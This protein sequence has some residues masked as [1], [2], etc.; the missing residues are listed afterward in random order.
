M[1]AVVGVRRVGHRMYMIL[2]IL[3][4]IWTALTI[5]G[6]DTGLNLL[7][8]N[9]YEES[10]S[11]NFYAQ[12]C[13]DYRMTLK[14]EEAEEK[15]SFSPCDRGC[16]CSINMVLVDGEVFI[17]T[18]LKGNQSVE[19]KQISIR[20]SI[21][22]KTPSI[23]SVEE[24]RGNFEIQW[25][26]NV[27]KK[28]ILD[29]LKAVVTYWKKGTNE[30]KTENLTANI[31]KLSFHEISG[32]DLEPSTTY[33]VSLKTYTPLSGRFSDSSNEKEFT[34]AV[35]PF[36][37][38]MVI[39]FILSIAA[40]IVS[41]AIFG[42][43]V[44]L[45]T[46]WWDRPV[47]CEKPT[48]LDIQPKTPKILTPVLPIIYPVSVEPTTPDAGK[49]G[50][51]ESL[52]Y[53]SSG[54]PKSSGI[55]MGS[56][57]SSY[58]NTE[59]VDVINSV[60]AA[61]M[62]TFPSFG[63]V[64]PGATNLLEES[65]KDSGLLSSTY[66]PFDVRAEASSSGSSCFYNKTYSIVIPSSPQ[67]ILT[68]VSEIQTQAEMPCES[69]Y[70]PSETDMSTC[71]AQPLINI[72]PVVSPAMTTD[73]SYQQCNNADSG[74]FSYAEDSSQSSLS[75]G[76]ESQC[77][78]FNEMMSDCMKENM[79]GEEVTRCDENPC[80]GGVPQDLHSSPLVDYE[81]QAFQSVVKQPDI[82]IPESR[83]S[84]NAPDESKPILPEI[85]TNTQSTV[86][87]PVCQ[88]PILPFISADQSTSL[89]VD[90]GYQSV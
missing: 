72:S 67:Q 6:A 7:C 22:P 13:S 75:S 26:T 71:Q 21:K 23:V 1:S 52:A 53:S 54:S 74:G 89:F 45:K 32:R 64:S 78:D 44:K 40:I 58:A 9:D 59:P 11:C 70:H 34:T 86:G 79:P 84:E 19:S 55:S 24:F 37:L 8:T 2:L 50:S 47:K 27:V 63:P 57:S 25:M 18:V 5:S 10:M 88:R 49:T 4:R 61:L 48:I 42:S 38:Q 81:Y 62:K 76:S 31:N 66:N 69:A 29:D 82:V 35:S 17:A 51:K 12:N 87:L 39:I 33:V 20:D 15:C 90:S 83:Y 80:Y 73:M 14:N 60:K 85:M 77:D 56:S 41:C 46:N 43:Y 16:C 28:S 68:G 36:S 3:G 30:T 65:D